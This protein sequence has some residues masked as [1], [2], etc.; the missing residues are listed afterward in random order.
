MTKERK[1]AKPHISIVGAGRLGT[2]LALALTKAGYQIQALVARRIA[3]VRKAAAVVGVPVFALTI[4]RIDELPPADL[5][6][7][8]TPDDDIAAVAEALANLNELPSNLKTVL[9]TSGALSAEVLDPL[10][11]RGVHTG[12]LHPLIAVSDSKSGANELKGAFYCV[13]GDKSAVRAARSIVKALKG[14]SIAIASSDKALYHAAAVMA[15]GHVV[16]LFDTALNLLVRS[17]LDQKLA[18]QALLPLVQSTVRNLSV[19][20]PARALTG[21][22]RRGDVATV[23]RHM[24]A[25]QAIE[26]AEPL[27]IYNALA[28][29]SLRLAR[30]QGLDSDLENSIVEVLD[31]VSEARRGSGPAKRSGRK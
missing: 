10:R 4:N 2:A 26:E 15:A 7:I 19:S 23:R 29:V 27:I 13:E 8:A 3:R 6:L 28:K 1:R 30:E 24:S 21:T 14:R 31:K 11:Q 9:H 16:A 20:P 5:L 17:G 22:F 18:R 12:S 25:L